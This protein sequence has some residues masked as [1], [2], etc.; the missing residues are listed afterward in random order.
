MKIKR[1]TYSS[2]DEN[3]IKSKTKFDSPVDYHGSPLTVKYKTKT[4]NNKIK[5]KTKFDSPTVDYKGPANMAPK[6]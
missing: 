6:Y 4:D 2:Y 1:D 3:K 5:R